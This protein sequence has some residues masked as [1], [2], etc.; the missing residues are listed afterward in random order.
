MEEWSLFPHFSFLKKY[1]NCSL[2][3]FSLFQERDTY[4]LKVGISSLDDSKKTF[5][6]FRG[7]VQIN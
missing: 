4:F 5:W 3:N 7:L 1:S 6:D 2:D